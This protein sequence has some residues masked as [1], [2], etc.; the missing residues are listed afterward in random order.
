[1]RQRH[2]IFF[3]TL[4]GK[5]SA[6]GGN[7]MIYINKYLLDKIEEEAA[8]SY[9]FECCGII[10]GSLESGKKIA[11]SI[12]SVVNSFGAGEEYHRFLI[13]AEDMMKGELYA[14]ANGLDMIGF[15]H[16]HP[17]H[18]AIPSEYDRSHA[19][20]VYSYLITSVL[21]GKAKDTFSYE[22]KNDIFETEEISVL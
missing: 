4:V 11:H 14:R 20:P 21:K 16:S 12:K 8:K 15:Y 3:G 2:K 17:D 22:L 7:T 6:A 5:L 18:P 19:L 10:F 13:T 9:P 1:M